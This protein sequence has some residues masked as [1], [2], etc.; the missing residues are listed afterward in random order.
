MTIRSRLRMHTR[1]R[2]VVHSVWP[3]RRRPLILMYHRIADNPVD[4]FGL[5]VCP[6]RFEEHLRVLRRTRY[7]LPLTDFVRDLVAGSLRSNAV[8]STFD[9]G[10]VDNLVAG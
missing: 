10:Y 4:Y 9:D 8:A 1:L 6:T 3:P 2:S 7:P 5:S